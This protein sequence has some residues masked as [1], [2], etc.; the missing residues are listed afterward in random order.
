[1]DISVD[2][3]QEFF[4][5]EISV[6]HSPVR[7]ILD[8]KRTTPRIEGRE[9]RLLLRHDLVL[10]DPFFAKELLR[11]LKENVGRYE[12]RFGEIKKPDN[13]KKAEAAVKKKSKSVSKSSSR[14]DYFG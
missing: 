12:K 6:S 9:Q 11:V 8:F 14:Q 7:F 4:A 5:D 3:G 2:N 10:I 1:M 13:L